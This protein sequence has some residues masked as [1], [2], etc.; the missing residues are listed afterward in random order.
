MKK[1]LLILCLIVLMSSC[2]KE[3]S[4]TLLFV[5]SYTEKLPGKG[6]KVYKFDSKTGEATLTH[7]VDSITNPSF[8]R[9]SPDGTTLYSVVESQMKNN[10][11]IARFTIDSDKGKLTFLDQIDCGGRNPVHIDIDSKNKYLVCS[12]YTDPSLCVFEINTNGKLAHSETLNFTGKSIIKGRQDEAHIHSSNF[13]PDDLCLFAQDL[14]TDNIR[15]FTVVKNGQNL[16][17]LSNEELIESAPGSGLRHFIFHPNKKYAYGICELSGKVNAYKYNNQNLEFIKE[18]KAYKS[19]LEIYSSAD[20]HIS[21]DGKFLYATNRGP[22][23]HSIVIFKID[24]SGTLTLVGHEPTYGEHPR[25]FAIDPTGE[26]LLVANQFT[27]NI[28][29]F[30]RNMETGKLTKLHHELEFDAPSSLQMRSYIK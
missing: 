6:I 5:G 27:N 18:Y 10:G 21:P 25:N 19:E 9:V 30:R 28:V 24:N 22:V 16:V 4:Q 15:K 20:I 1:E 13:S 26:F 17:S 2:K 7:E 23:E 8:L 12:N 14:G 29:F 3:N 11:K